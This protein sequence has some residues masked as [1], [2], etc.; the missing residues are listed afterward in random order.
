VEGA[1][2]LVRAVDEV[3]AVVVGGEKV[4]TNDGAETEEDVVVE[5][6]EA[7]RTADGGVNTGR[8]I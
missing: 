5:L 8:G 6:V 3:V 4:E 1:E 2:A 7:E